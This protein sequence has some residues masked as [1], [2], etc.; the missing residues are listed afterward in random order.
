MKPI[1]IILSSEHETDAVPNQYA[2]YFAPHQALLQTHRSIDFGASAIASALQQSFNCQLIT[3]TITR[4]IIDCNRSLTDP[5]CF[6][7]ISESFSEKEKK[8][9]IKTYYLPYRNKIIKHI[10]EQL[11]LGH[12]V[13]H[14]S[15]HSF[16]PILNGITR[17]T[18]FGLL[19]DPKRLIEKEV[20]L[21][22][23]RNL[24]SRSDFQV[25]LNY[26]YKGNAD[27][28]TTHCR[29]LFPENYVG[30]EVETNQA[31]VK[32]GDSLVKVIAA[33]TTSLKAIVD[34]TKYHQSNLL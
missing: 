29:E 28:L 11:T 16:T 32:E 2:H 8:A 21:K 25:R 33:L 4:L 30:I 5:H 13:W 6:S 7:E 3:A 15:I 14:L 1:T 20:V 17:T 34:Y 18:D 26:P 27:G 10:E 23:Q 24:Q 31:L 9:L 12:V 19:Y 22:W